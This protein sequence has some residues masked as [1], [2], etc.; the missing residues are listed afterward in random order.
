MIENF[1]IHSKAEEFNEGIFDNVEIKD[2]EKVVCLSISKGNNGYANRGQYTSEILEAKAFKKLVLSWNCNTPEGT[3]VEIQGR[4][5]ANTS[6]AIKG[7][8]QWF[9]WGI[10]GTYLKRQSA[11]AIEDSIAGINT[12]TLVVKDKDGET[13]TKLQYRLILVS[14]NREATPNISLVVGTLESEESSLIA[15]SIS[16]NI[17]YNK[18]LDVPMLSQMIREPKIAGSICSPTSI[19]MIMGYYGTNLLPEETAWGVYDYVY[20][21][22]GNWSFN[23][24]FTASYNYEAYVK[25]LNIEELKTEIYNNHPVAVSVKYRNNSAVESDLPIID[26]A[27]IRKT[28][29]HLI[30]VCGFKN[31][32]GIEYIVVND[33][34]AENDNKVNISYRLEQF[35]AAWEKSG[36]IAYMIQPKKNKIRTAYRQA[37]VLTQVGSSKDEYELQIDDNKI[38]LDKNN[39]RTIMVSDNDG[40]SYRYISP[41]ENSNI[42]LED[43]KHPR[44]LAFVFISGEG[45]TY[46]ADITFKD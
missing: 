23:T 14:D 12:D 40:I 22:F 6:D 46:T 17:N 9:S 15:K 34:A 25:N 5:F 10:W 37:G 21:G 36:R 8:S 43:L 19:T 31:I 42:K 4:V 24:A 29:G 45:K 11:P 30:V 16:E 7:W 18:I 20:E 13:A 44:K 1:F 3:F 28:N 35:E 41:T 27:P 2:K 38:S 32:N 39:I 26:G 33:P